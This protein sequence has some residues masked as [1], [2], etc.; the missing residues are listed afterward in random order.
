MEKQRY[1]KHLCF[2]Y[3]KLYI[4]K[5]VSFSQTTTNKDGS[6]KFECQHGPTE[7]LANMYHACSIEAI[8]EPKVL[9]D[10]IAC[11]IRD[12]T[13]PKEAMQKVS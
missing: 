1:I 7:C 12:N 13:D 2:Q 11:M 6:L 5:A 9:L 3:L 10:V 8:D 4:K